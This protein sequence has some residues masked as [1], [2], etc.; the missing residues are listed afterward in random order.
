MITVPRK[1]IFDVVKTGFKL[2]KKDLIVQKG[3]GASQ[4]P[5]SILGIYLVS[6]NPEKTVQFC[7]CPA[8]VA[9]TIRQRFRK[10]I[11]TSNSN[12]CF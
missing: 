12:H 9:R 8:K 1:N 10:M 5:N 4:R 11:L 7:V 3:P 2:I 6:T